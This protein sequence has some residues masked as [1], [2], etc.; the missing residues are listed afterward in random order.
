MNGVDCVSVALIRGNHLRPCA[1]LSLS[2]FPLVNNGNAPGVLFRVSCR[3]ILGVVFNACFAVGFLD[4]I[5]AGALVMRGMVS[6]GVSSI[7][8][9]SCSLTLCF[10][11][12]FCGCKACLIFACRFLIRRCPVGVPFALSTTSA[13]SS[14]SALKC[15]C[16][17]KHGNWQCWGNNSVDP[18][19]WY[20]LISGM[21]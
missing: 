21:K 5:I 3:C 8:L 17:V 12:T 1:L 20:A 15:W 6:M 2:C 10:S 13:N 14:V 4:C 19:I 16:C 11:W 18:E 9:C 7:T